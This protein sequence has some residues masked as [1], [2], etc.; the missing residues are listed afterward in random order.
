[1]DIKHQ[2]IREIE[3]TPASMHDSQIDLTQSGE[4]TYHDRGYFG[5]K[6]KGHNATMN[7]ATRDHP[8]KIRE[9]LKNK[10]ITHKKAPEERPYA[11]IKNIF[12]SGHVKVTT[13]LRTHTKN[14]FTCFC[15]NLLQLN[16]IQHQNTT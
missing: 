10:R 4:V 3:T 7:R 1:M 8:L 2:L 13:T 5:G 12:H 15:Y 14:I 16:T 9:K 6:C 11:V